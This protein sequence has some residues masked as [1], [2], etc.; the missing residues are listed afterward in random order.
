MLG[1][2]NNA[3]CEANGLELIDYISE[4]DKKGTTHEET[5]MEEL[6]KS[7]KFN[8]AK[9]DDLEDEKATVSK[10]NKEFKKTHKKEETEEVN[11]EIKSE[12]LN[13]KTLAELK[14]MA[15]EAGVKG[16]SQ[17]KKEELI[18]NLK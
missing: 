18:N 16:Y 11:T 17:M 1:V 5:R 4:E 2:L 13:S 7:D 8:T 6:I 12:D 10:P 3:I 14:N 9:K 15:K